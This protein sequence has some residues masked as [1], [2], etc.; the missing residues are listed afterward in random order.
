[1]H[2]IKHPTYVGI[3]CPDLNCV[4]CVSIYVEYIRTE[5]PIRVFGGSNDDIYHAFLDMGVANEK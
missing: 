2:C 4:N 5:K 3:T 1:M